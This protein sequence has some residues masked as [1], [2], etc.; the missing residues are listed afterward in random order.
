MF[1]NMTVGKKIIVGF[2][3]VLALVVVLGLIA[4][5]ALTGASDG[6]KQYREMARDTNLASLLESDMLM[7]RMNVKDFIISGSDKDLHE[8]QGHLDDMHRY[9]E[10]AQKQI[11]APE[12]AKQVDFVDDEVEEYK[13]GFERVAEF[14]KKRNHIVDNILSKD[15]KIME[16]DLSAIMESADRDDDIQAAFRAGVALKHLLLGRL[17]VVK[18]LDSNS[19][20]DADRVNAEFDLVED[21]LALLD[22]HLENLERRELLEKVD[23]ADHEY[24]ERFK[25]LVNVIFARNEIIEG[26]LDRIGPEIAKAVEDVKLDIQGVQDEIGPRLQASNERAE[27]LITV[28]GLISLILGVLMTVIITRAITKPIG[29]AIEDLDEGADQVASASGQVSSSSQTLAEGASEQASS[30]EETSSSLEEVA[31]MTKQ[32]AD[33]ANQ[34]DNLMKEANQ[35]VNRAN[36]SMG[37]VTSSMEEISKASEETSKIIKTIDDVAFQTNLLALNAAVEAAR[38]GEAGA[39]FAVVADEVRNLAMRAADAA[40]NTSDLIEGTVKKVKDGSE[41]VT[42]TNEAFSEVSKSASKVGELVSEIAAASNEQ[43]S[44]IEQVNQAVAEMDKVT[45]TTAANAEESASASEELNSQAEQMK[46]VVDEL[47]KLVGAREG[48]AAQQQYGRTRQT[49]KGGSKTATIVHKTPPAPEKEAS[50]KEVAV[51]QK[52]EVKPDEVIPMN[53]GDFKN[54]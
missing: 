22:E 17:Y 53:D 33:S 37:E 4:F 28:V 39:G 50:S 48:R 46:G 34:A 12:R 41:L 11:Q 1:K 2:S 30:L 35:V 43:S 10:Q 18:F 15:G 24:H 51:Q 52:T 6:F 5:N 8:Y 27:I 49:K 42:K 31:S 21:Q 16:D 38:A 40:K 29:R 26:T 44:G 54:F 14:K 3:L 25:E 9:L 23:E 20:Q 7:V 19:Q 32:N 47:V 45:Q 13:N 36:Q